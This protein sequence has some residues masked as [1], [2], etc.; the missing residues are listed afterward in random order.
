[1]DSNAGRFQDGGVPLGALGD[2]LFA[3]LRAMASGAKSAG[4]RA[5][6]SQASSSIAVAL[7]R[8][9]RTSLPLSNMTSHGVC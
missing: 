5:G 6:H 3:Q 4:E 9:L 1:M 8:L 2:Q 7:L